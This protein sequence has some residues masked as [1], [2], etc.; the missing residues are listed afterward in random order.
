VRANC[1][2][3]DR[4]HD[5]RYFGLI[6]T[7]YYLVPGLIVETPLSQRIGGG[8]GDDKEDTAN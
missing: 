4:G 7:G 1:F 8:D 2:V 5:S 3:K 6:R